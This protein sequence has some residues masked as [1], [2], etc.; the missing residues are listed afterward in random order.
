MRVL[1]ADDESLVRS[2]L[3]SMLEELHLPLTLIGEAKNGDETIQMVK[4]S[5]PD[6]VFVDIRMPKCNGLD[7]IRKAKPFSPE[8]Q[9]IILSGYSNFEYA[10]EAINLGAVNYLNKPVSPEEL[11]ETL[12]KLQEQYQQKNHKLNNQFESEIISHYYSLPCSNESNCLLMNKRFYGSFLLIDSHLPETF[13]AEQLTKISHHLRKNINESQDN[14]WK[15]ALMLLSNGELA[16]VRGCSD[17]K[18]TKRTQ[19]FTDF[20]ENKEILL[21]ANK[22]PFS[23]TFFQSN[24][25]SSVELL[26]QQMK[27]LQELSPLRTVVGVNKCL[28]V[29][30]LTSWGSYPELLELS[31]LLIDLAESFKNLEYLT[32]MNIVESIETI[33]RDISNNLFTKI[34]AHIA[35]FLHVSIGLPL[36]MDCSP[37]SL[38][39]DL[40]KY[41]EQVLKEKSK[42]SFSPTD[43]ITQ[44]VSYI[45]QHYAT[46]IGLNQIANQLNVTPNYLSTLFRKKMGITFLKYLTRIRMLKAKDLLSNPHIQVQTVAENVGYFSTRHFTKLFYEY[47]GC[48]PSE[49]RDRRRAN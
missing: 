17:Q 24:L 33:L 3:I 8:T 46:E 42:D 38:A 30:D 11:A 15:S 44:V 39:E 40:S 9:W 13:Q 49:F 48:Y 14:L 41:S 27:Q 35:H 22:Q 2:S 19:P 18:T 10:K 4:T 7:V 5:N 47:F 20:R 16:S 45:D 26:F 34:Q 36:Y 37:K 25:C 12:T 6:I 21:H 28:S 32:Y 1:I 31:K 23:I 43:L 29:K